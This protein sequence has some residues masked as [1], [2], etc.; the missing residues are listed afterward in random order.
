M[1]LKDVGYIS[2]KQPI[3]SPN[4]AAEA[5]KHEMKDLDREELIVVNLNSSGKPI[6]WNI[7]SIGGLSAVHFWIPNL[8]KTAILSNAKS[9]IVFHNHPGG[10][11]YPSKEDLDMTKMVHDACKIIGIFMIDHIIVSGTTDDYYSLKE[12]GDFLF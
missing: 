5:I 12:N 1:Y 6:N 4:L 7:V 10:T 9:F 11:L 8:F 3:T 2:A